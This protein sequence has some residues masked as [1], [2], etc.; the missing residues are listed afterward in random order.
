MGRS[1]VMLGIPLQ[2]WLRKCGMQLLSPPLATILL[3]THATRGQLPA[4]Y[5]PEILKKTDSLVQLPRSDVQF[6]IS[7]DM[8]VLIS[9]R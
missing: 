3:E 4:Q 1:G 8:V 6:V 2:F 7:E 5:S 9:D